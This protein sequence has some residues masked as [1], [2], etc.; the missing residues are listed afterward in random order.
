VK[1]APVG[2]RVLD[3]G[4]APRQQ[5]ASLGEVLFGCCRCCNGERSGLAHRREQSGS[6]Q[7]IL[8][9]APLP[10][11]LDPDVTRAQPITQRQQG[12]RFPNP[13]LGTVAQDGFA[14]SRPEKAGRQAA[15]PFSAATFINRVLCLDRPEPRRGGRKGM[16]AERSKKQ[17]PETVQ[18]RPSARA[19][20]REIRFVRTRKAAARTGRS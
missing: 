8:D 13:A 5:G 17:R 2:V 18:N 11:A 3:F 14:P 7:L 9:R 6:K 15:R 4:E 19:E 12:G 10:A 16:K 1:I 20:G